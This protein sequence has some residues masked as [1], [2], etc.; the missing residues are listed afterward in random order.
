MAKHFLTDSKY[1]I[2]LEE[3]DQ[4]TQPNQNAGLNVTD[5]TIIKDKLLEQFNSK[6]KEIENLAI[7]DAQAKNYSRDLYGDL[8][9]SFS[10]WWTS[11]FGN[12][13]PVKVKSSYSTYLGAIYKAVFE[14]ND[15]YKNSTQETKTAT[16]YEQLLQNA[17]KEIEYAKSI[18]QNGMK[19][20][21]EGNGQVL[22]D[23]INAG[24]AEG[25][26]DY[27]PGGKKTGETREAQAAPQQTTQP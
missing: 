26:K 5:T 4:N 23:A 2:L 15:L 19:R 17:Q 9:K 1:K 24:M 10:T 8:D 16:N 18:G 22:A 6:A 11:N 14:Y 7:Q 12:V 13:V 21:Q 3:V 20:Y 25:N 27:A